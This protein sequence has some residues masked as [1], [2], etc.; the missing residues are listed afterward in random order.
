MP[1]NPRQLRNSGLEA[2]TFQ[3]QSLNAPAWIDNLGADP[4]NEIIACRNG[5]LHV[6]TRTLLQ[7]TPTFFTHHCV[8]FDYDPNAPTPTRWLAFL[9][10]LWPDDPESIAAL[11]EGFGYLVSGDTSLQKIF[12]LVGPKLTTIT[13]MSPVS[14]VESP[15][16]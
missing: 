15:H 5:L 13:G 14:I 8:P 16:V 3:P 12:L 1:T 2:I 7:H 10:E 9:E 6:P 4:A 11:Q